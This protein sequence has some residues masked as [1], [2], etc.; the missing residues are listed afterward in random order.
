MQYDEFR[1]GIFRFK[2]LCE[3]RRPDL[4]RK[5]GHLVVSSSFLQKWST[6]AVMTMV[7]FIQ[8][9]IYEID[10]AIFYT[11]LPVHEL[12]RLGKFW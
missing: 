4:F 9:I 1:K 11:N 7:E 10:C 3:I 6:P 8:V 12:N 5:Q 2:D